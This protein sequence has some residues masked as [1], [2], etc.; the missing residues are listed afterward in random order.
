MIE[1]KYKEQIN[2]MNRVLFSSGAKVSGQAGILKYLAD[3][4]F[5]AALL[6]ENKGT[7]LEGQVGV[8]QEGALESYSFAPTVA[9]D[10]AIMTFL[11]NGDTVY[12]EPYKQ[13]E[14]IIIVEKKPVALTNLFFSVV[15]VPGQPNQAVSL[16]LISRQELMG[17]Q[18]LSAEISVMLLA[19]LLKNEAEQKLEL[20]AK[21]KALA[22]AAFGSL[23]YSELEAITEVLKNIKDHESVVVASKIADG[24]GITRSV[25]VNALRKLESAGI[26]ESRSLGMKGTFIRVK[27]PHVLAMISSRSATTGLYV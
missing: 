15:P 12:N 19:Q 23:S 27:N 6:V 11:K 25:I 9:K 2:T 4:T 20:E 16:V 24:L 18:I 5:S 1:E 21:N 13:T 26:I 8:L 3:T 22:E 7:V 10:S 17:P 14:K